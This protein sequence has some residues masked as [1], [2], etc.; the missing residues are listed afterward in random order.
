VSKINETYFASIKA[1]WDA[2]KDRIYQENR[3]HRVGDE[4]QNIAM[5]QYLKSLGLKIYYKDDSMHISAMS[6]FPDNLVHYC[7]TKPFDVPQIDFINLWVW[8]PFLQARGIY[9]KTQ[10]I[11]E[12]DK[13]TY[14]VVFIPC[15]KPEYNFTRGLLTN[16]VLQIYDFL[17]K[18]FKEVRMIVDAQKINLIQKKDP[19]I[20]FSNNMHTTFRYIEKSKIFIGCDTGTSHYAGAIKHPRMLLLY[21]DEKPMQKEI[22]W[23]KD[24]ISHVF[25]VP[26]LKL[27]QPS[28]MPCCPKNNMQIMTL[29]NNAIDPIEV[30]KVILNF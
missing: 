5:M 2:R 28:S 6:I 14:D 8:S 20:I 1:R 27:Y 24:L 12:E 9:T 26:E 15:L 16:N 18:S 21:P 3:I 17:K 22:L 7:N 23:Q 25:S 13:T 4:I 29:K 10:K 19:N 11:Y 30:M